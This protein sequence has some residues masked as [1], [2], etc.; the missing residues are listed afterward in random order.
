MSRYSRIKAG[1]IVRIFW[2]LEILTSPWCQVIVLNPELTPRTSE[3]FQF[4]LRI[5]RFQEFKNITTV[6][7]WKT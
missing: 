2:N 5:G 1:E 4:C 3:M 6:E 7:G